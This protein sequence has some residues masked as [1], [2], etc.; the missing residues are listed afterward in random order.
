MSGLVGVGGTDNGRIKDKRPLRS[1]VFAYRH[2]D[3]ASDTSIS[4]TGCGFKPA[5]AIMIG[6]N[7]YVNV[8]MGMASAENNAS[9]CYAIRHAYYGGG[10]TEWMRFQQGAF[11]SYGGGHPAIYRA[12]MS[13]T[14]GWV[15]S[16]ESWDADGITLQVDTVYA[17]GSANMDWGIILFG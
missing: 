4:F 7:L 11:G 6:A 5:G 17:S 2:L 14:D 3:S 13:N 1:K 16:V 9:C 15:V 12:T 8:G 10:G